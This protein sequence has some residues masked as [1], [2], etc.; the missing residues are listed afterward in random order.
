MTT[1]L[2]A[3]RYPV[4]DLMLAYPERWEVARAISDCTLAARLWWEV[5][6]CGGRAEA[7]R[8]TSK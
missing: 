2:D 7:H 8:Y 6:V 3:E 5:V 4:L 1:L